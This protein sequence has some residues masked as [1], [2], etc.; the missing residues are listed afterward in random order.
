MQAYH[1]KGGQAAKTGTGGHLPGPKVTAEIAD[2]R[3]LQAGETA[4]SPSRFP[5]WT[6]PSH[7]AEFATEVRER[8]SGIPIGFK[9][10]AQHI[11]SVVKI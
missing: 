6:Q 2:V 4:I 5:E 9:L 7:F 1:F 3:G 11:V 8:T 10:S